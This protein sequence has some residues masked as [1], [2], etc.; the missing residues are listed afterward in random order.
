MEKRALGKGLSALLPERASLQEESGA[1]ILAKIEQVRPNPLQPRE[2][3]DPVRM[4]ELIQS[5]K[6]KGVIQP[7]VARK[8]GDIFELIAG[9]RRFRAAQHL[10]LSEIPVL[11]KEANDQEALEIALIENI[12]RQDLNAIEEARAYQYLIDKFQIT[13]ERIS[14][15]LGKARA[16]VAN[17]LRLLNLPAEV[18]EDIRGG[19]LSFA[20]GRALLEL[21]DPHLQRRLAHEAVIKALS[22]RELETLLRRRSPRAVRQRIRSLAGKDPSLV[23]AE[24]RLQQALGT[25][26]RITRRKKRGEIAIEF[27][28]PDDLSRLV[29][30]MAGG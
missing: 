13:Q 18:Q 10:Q 2:D 24:E 20:H 3:F 7:V 8:K 6:E 15:V 25:K 14:V 16:S 30:K 29:D 26:V 22:V 23:A 28:S 19:R 17:T 27:Y 21:D 5:I 1:V 9:E 4:Q 11:L 12:Q